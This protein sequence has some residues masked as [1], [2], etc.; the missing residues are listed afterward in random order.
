MRKESESVYLGK[1]GR[2]E[3]PDPGGLP[4]V[5]SGKGVEDVFLWEHVRL[6]R[7]QGKRIPLKPRRKLSPE[8]EARLRR[9]LETMAHHARYALAY[10]EQM[11]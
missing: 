2:F 9:D 3:K 5:S 1:Y 6:L 10:L 4:D 8:A 11:R 7:S